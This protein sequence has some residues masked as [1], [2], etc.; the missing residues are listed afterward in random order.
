MRSLTYNAGKIN[1]VIFITFF[2]NDALSSESQNELSC[3]ATT[4]QR[5]LPCLLECRRPH[6]WRCGS[7]EYVLYIYAFKKMW[8]EGLITM[9]IQIHNFCSMA[10]LQAIYFASSIQLVYSIFDP[11][12]QK[13]FHFSL[14][15]YTNILELEMRQV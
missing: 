13:T 7:A 1:H 3:A 2:K 15:F 14:I 11:F 6:Q 9:I 10:Q 4:A 12:K 5:S 8:T